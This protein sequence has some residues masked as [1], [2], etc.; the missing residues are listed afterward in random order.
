[1]KYTGAQMAFTLLAI[2]A[3]TTDTTPVSAVPVRLD[4][5]LTN[6]HVDMEGD[7][8][9]DKI[10]GHGA[11]AKWAIANQH[12][13]GFSGQFGVQ[14]PPSANE[15]NWNAD[16]EAKGPFNAG[17]K[18]NVNGQLALNDGKLSKTVKGDS[19]FIMPGIASLMTK[20][21]A[22][23]RIGH[24][25]DG[26]GVDG[27]GNL[28]G[29][30]T[31]P[32]NTRKN[33]GSDEQEQ[34]TGRQRDFELGGAVQANG[35]VVVKPG[36]VKFTGSGSANGVF[37]NDEKRNVLDSTLDGSA[38]GKIGSSGL[39]TEVNLQAKVFTDLNGSEK[40][41]R[42]KLQSGAAVQASGGSMRLNGFANTDGTVKSDD[43]TDAWASTKSTL[44][45]SV[46]IE[47]G[48]LVAGGSSRN[49]ALA[50]S[51]GKEKDIESADE[52]IP[53]FIGGASMDARLDG[54][55]FRALGTVD[56]E[57]QNDKNSLDINRSF[58]FPRAAK[59]KPDEI[60]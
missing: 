3:I 32:G 51:G 60:S 37:Q 24:I 16:M 10:K 19:R 8:Y 14:I 6:W 55:K 46:G 22:S 7:S 21:G 20:A 57:Y 40:I 13:A 53:T 4:V 28:D 59:Q 25:D 39:E 42:G 26:M 49:T 9:N 15:I 2:A 43:G 44:N 23:A 58:A 56:A 1:M 33:D 50:F 27:D 29:R 11:S 30:F 5:P 17:W 54:I 48:R 36:S 47:N 18:G 38:E 35:N 34:H 12:D 41:V 52:L 45:G 31:I